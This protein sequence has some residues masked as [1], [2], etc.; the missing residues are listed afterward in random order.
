MVRR[1]RAHSTASAEACV[2]NGRGEQMARPGL[3]RIFNFACVP[4]TLRLARRNRIPPS[5]HPASGQ[6]ERRLPSAA[7]RSRAIGL[8]RGSVLA[9]F[10][11]TGFGRGESTCESRILPVVPLA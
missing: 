5:A 6:P 11:T 8:G 9:P 4:F 1:R 7:A 10:S 2:V 3:A